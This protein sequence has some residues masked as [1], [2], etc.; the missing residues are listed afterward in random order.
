MSDNITP[1]TT[2]SKK[3]N[4]KK[5]AMFLDAVEA[6]LK[7]LPQHLRRLW[8]PDMGLQVNYQNG[9]NRRVPHN[10][11]TT[12]PYYDDM[13]YYLALTDRSVLGVGVN[14]WNWVDQ[15]SEF[16][17]FDLDSVLNHAGGVSPAKL[18]EV[19]EKLKKLELEII[20]SKSGH[21]YHVRAHFDPYPSALS[22]TQHAKNAKKVLGWIGK[23]LDMPITESVDCFGAIAWIWH[24]DTGP[25]GFEIIKPAVFGTNPT[26]QD[27][28]GMV[29]ETDKPLTEEVAS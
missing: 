6:F 21:G 10:G 4:N 27:A 19:V 2:A 11:R 16:V 25:N 8:R 15:V 12:S 14:G 29:S 7:P 17:T 13:P 28:Q 3:P 18:R 9:D 20:R 5:P 22:H 24:K 23:T 26:A 1:T